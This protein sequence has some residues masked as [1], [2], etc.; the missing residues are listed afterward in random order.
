MLVNVLLVVGDNRLGDSL[1]DGVDLRCVTTT[2]DPHAYI[3]LR[4]LVEADDEEWFVDLQDI[5]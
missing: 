3:N 1:T 5:W 4:K 2:R